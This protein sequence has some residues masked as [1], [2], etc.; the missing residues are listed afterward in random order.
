LTPFSRLSVNG[1]NDKHSFR[2]DSAGAYSRN[3]FPKSPEQMEATFS[4]T[5]IE[6]EQDNISVALSLQNFNQS[7]D[8]VSIK[9]FNESLGD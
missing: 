3:R 1:G 9:S 2:K 4:M 8:K 7:D 6:E 5:T